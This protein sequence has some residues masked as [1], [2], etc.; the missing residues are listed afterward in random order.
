MK[1]STG[2]KEANRGGTGRLEMPAY[3]LVEM[4]LAVAIIALLA[5]MTL[6]AHGRVQE[7][8]RGLTARH[9]IAAL[10]MLLESERHSAGG[11]HLSPAMLADPSGNAE[12]LRDPWRRPY[13]VAP[14]ATVE[15]VH[16]EP[17]RLVLEWFENDFGERLFLQVRPLDE[18]EVH[19]VT[20]DISSVAGPLVIPGGDLPHLF[21]IDP[22][23]APGSETTV[24]ISLSGEPGS[25][26]A[27][28]LGDGLP[29]PYPLPALL[30]GPRQPYLV[31]SL[32]A[33]RRPDD[34]YP[35]RE[36]IR[37]IDRDIAWR[38][39]FQDFQ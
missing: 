7:R 16:P 15:M 28:F 29:V 23:P 24:E 35:D 33:D 17:L 38:S 19:E 18:K 2:Q 36:A 39:D 21:V 27:L 14:F 6:I 32:G 10:F 37:D 8:A 22:A 13:L 34:L 20:L 4:L 25:G 3:T 11:I 26:I 5:T 30:R 12:H 31:M 1:I 9:E